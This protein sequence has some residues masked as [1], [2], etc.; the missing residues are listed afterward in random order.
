MREWLLTGVSQRVRLGGHDI[1]I[2]VIKRRFEAGLKNFFQLYRTLVSSWLF[3]DNSPQTRPL[4][5]A[6][7]ERQTAVE[8]HDSL[9]YKTFL[10]K[11]TDERKKKY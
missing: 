10:R 11:Y 1:P 4:L 8:I 6:A 9:M 2:A 5:V 3:Y 7:G